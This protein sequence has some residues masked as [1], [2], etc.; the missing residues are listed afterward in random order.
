MATFIEHDAAEHAAA[1]SL[2]SLSL[3]ALA[4][5]GQEENEEDGEGEEDQVGNFPPII[6]VPSPATRQRKATVKRRS[7]R[8]LMGGRVSVFT[9]SASGATSSST[10]STSKGEDASIGGGPGDSHHSRRAEISAEVFTGKKSAPYR[11][12]VVEKDAS[13]RQFIRS[14]V[15]SCMLFADLNESGR[16]EVVDAF[17][18]ITAVRGQL[19]IEEGDWGDLFY[20]L[21]SGTCD[22]IKVLFKAALNDKVP[23]KV[24][25]YGPGGSFGELA[26]MYNEPRAATI[27]VTSDS[28]ELW[29][30]DRLTY[31]NISVHFKVQKQKQNEEALRH[32]Q[33]LYNLPS[34]DMIRLVDIAEEHTY[35]SGESV[36]KIGDLTDEVLV[37]TQG[38]LLYSTVKETGQATIGDVF[39]EEA[40][41]K[42]V[43]SEFSLHPADKQAAVLLSLSRSKM[44]EIIGPLSARNTRNA[45]PKSVMM[46]RSQTNHRYHIAMKFEDLDT[47]MRVFKGEPTSPS[48]SVVGGRQSPSVV[49][50]K[51]LPIMTSTPLGMAGRTVSPSFASSVVSATNGTGRPNMSPGF[52]SIASNGNRAVSGTHSAV[53]AKELVLGVG[54]FGKVIICKHV[55]TGETYAMKKLIKSWIVEN[56]LEQH[57]VDERNVMTLTDHPFILKL[58]SSFWD[59][60]YVY[61]VLELCLGGELFTYLRKYDKFNEQQARFYAA[62]IVQ[63]FE[64]LHSKSI[65]YRDLKPENLML[66]DRGFLKVVDFGLAKVVKGRTWTICGTPEY[67][68]PEVVMSKGHN[69]G[70]DY[71]ALGILIFEMVAGV[72]PFE[73]D[74]NMQIYRLIVENKISF[75]TFMTPDCREIIRDFTRVSQLNRLGLRRPGIKAIRDHPWFIGFDWN[76]L[77]ALKLQPP[78]VPKV[79]N[80]LDTSNFEEYMDDDTTQ[81]PDVCPWTPLFPYEVKNGKTD[82]VRLFFLLLK[83]ASSPGPNWI[84]FLMQNF[85]RQKSMRE[86]DLSS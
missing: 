44:E 45:R 17:S 69:R 32:V 42:Q 74:D 12:T 18:K 14:A 11:K 79:R 54:T 34:E 24:K 38:N 15:D 84:H 40:L 29:V 76:L 21:V 20:V 5:A 66:D 6:D 68:A 23:S 16:N 52:V 9:A 35:G 8:H 43:P 33:P 77:D 27:R 70:V 50:V 49:G 83:K 59:E 57:V 26:L 22:A 4:E 72:C 63:A 2:Q 58:H 3:E 37:F 65:I 73:G 86:V 25:S 28:A 39:N 67:L 71:W 47:N 30:I 41:F 31:K 10:L 75:P 51:Q 53:Q 81:E 13:T 1:I 60:R 36:I 62:S 64:H 80:R 56:C 61:L 7:P 85:A 48:S 82:F 78:I 19:L 55:P 46:P